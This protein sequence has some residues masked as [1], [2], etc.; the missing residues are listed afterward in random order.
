MSPD[1]QKT[2]GR[3]QLCWQLLWREAQRPSARSLRMGTRGLPYAS[4]FHRQR[5]LPG[6]LEVLCTSQLLQC[7]AVLGAEQVL[8]GC[9]SQR[10]MKFAVHR[11]T[12]KMGDPVP[13]P[14]ALRQA[15]TLGIADKCLSGHPS[16]PCCG[17]GWVHLLQSPDAPFQ[18]GQVCGM[19]VT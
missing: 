4:G 8:Q 11:G 18:G 14:A 9:K 2:R 15:V 10:T 12:E 16:P 17:M 19:E 13:V 1:S 5:V 6:F 3:Q 7:P